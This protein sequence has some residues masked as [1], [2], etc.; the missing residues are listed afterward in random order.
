M[1]TGT[2]TAFLWNVKETE[3]RHWRLAGRRCG[4][5]VLAR[6]ARDVNGNHVPNY[7][8]IH[9]SPAG[10]GVLYKEFLGMEQRGEIQVEDD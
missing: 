5:K 1:T 6:I 7:F 9:A 8:A 4:I 3:I 10:R 2:K